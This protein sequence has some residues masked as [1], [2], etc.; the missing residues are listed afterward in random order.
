MPRPPIYDNDLRVRLL[1]VTAEFVD[2]AGVAAVSLRELARRAETS[3]SAI[4]ALFGGKDELLAAVIDDAFASFTS[5][6]SEA[7]PHGLRALG[8]AYRAWALEHPALYRLMFSTPLAR[9]IPAAEGDAAHGPLGPLQNV[10]ARLRPNESPEQH[11]IASLAIW[12]QVHGAVSLQFT[13][14][15]APHE[16]WDAVYLSIVDQIAQTYDPSPPSP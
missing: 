1:A 8:L 2:E 10:V 3:T 13:D 6:Q 9:V 7:E 4:Y 5:S 11:A 16:A 15:P 14:M 12:S